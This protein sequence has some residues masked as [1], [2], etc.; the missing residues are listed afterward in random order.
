MLLDLFPV[1][2]GFG[3]VATRGHVAPPPPAVLRIVE[4]DALTALVGAPAHTWQFAKDERIGCRLDDGNDQA[5]ERV[6]DRQTGEV[7]AVLNSEDTL[8]QEGQLRSFKDD[9]TKSAPTHTHN[10]TS[11]KSGAR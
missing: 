10:A 3:A 7:L 5:S 2:R 11:A 4:E 9:V 6:A 8:F 1:A